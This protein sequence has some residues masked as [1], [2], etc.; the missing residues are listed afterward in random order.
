[1]HQRSLAEKRGENVEIMQQTGM[2]M[3]DLRRQQNWSKVARR[4]IVNLLMGSWKYRR[5]R[6]S[7]I[8]VDRAYLSEL[9]L[10]G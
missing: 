1:M 6:P 2:D 7:R 8:H 10:K 3:K 5:A 4:R 9:S